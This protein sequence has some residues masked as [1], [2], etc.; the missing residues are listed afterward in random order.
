MSSSEKRKKVLTDKVL[1]RP[2]FDLPR[3]FGPALWRIWPTTVSLFLKSESIE[4]NQKFK[5]LLED[6]GVGKFLK[7]SRASRSTSSEIT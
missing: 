7:A 3:Y 5:F 1:S 6:V 4:I 2:N